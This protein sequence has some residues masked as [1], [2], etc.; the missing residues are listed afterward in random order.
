MH[1]FRV[2]PCHRTLHKCMHISQLNDN[3][4]AWY[5]ETYRLVFVCVWGHT[6][7]EIDEL[8]QQISHSGVFGTGQNLA[9]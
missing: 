4:A 1:A 5:A 9:A 2:V 7:N 6:I 3:V 8:W